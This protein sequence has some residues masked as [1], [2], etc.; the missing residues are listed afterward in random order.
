MDY[1]PYASKN[2]ITL[3]YLSF[4]LSLHSEY[5]IF[6]TIEI[7]LLSPMHLSYFDYF[8]SGLQV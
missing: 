8:S 2:L 3:N 1:R 5:S 4:L 6:L 7:M